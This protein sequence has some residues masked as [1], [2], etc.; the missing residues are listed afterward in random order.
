MSTAL[1]YLYCHSNLEV[2]VYDFSSSFRHATGSTR[3]DNKNPI[4]LIPLG[5]C[6]DHLP[7]AAYLNNESFGWAYTRV[8][9]TI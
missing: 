5:L 4:L 6:L 3:D 7:L 2:C 1:L 8:V 9:D